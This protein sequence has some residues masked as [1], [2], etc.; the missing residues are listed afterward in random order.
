MNKI[1]IINKIL[2]AEIMISGDWNFV[3]KVYNEKTLSDLHLYHFFQKQH[4]LWMRLP[5]IYPIITFTYRKV[6]FYPIRNSIENPYS[7]TVEP[8]EHI[9]DSSKQK[10]YLC[11]LNFID[12]NGMESHLKL[13]R[14]TENINNTLHVCKVCNESVVDKELNIQCSKCL[15]IYH[16]NCTALKEARGKWKSV[17]WQCS[18]CIA[19]SSTTIE[20]SSSRVKLPSLL[21]RQRKSNVNI[22]DPQIEFLK[23]QV[24]TLKGVIV[25][26]N[27]EIRKLKQSNELKAKRIN[28][29]ESQIRNV[30]TKSASEV[31]DSDS[32]TSDLKINLLEQKLANAMKQMN[33]MNVKLAELDQRMTTRIYHCTDCNFETLQD[34]NLRKHM[35]ESH[36]KFPS[37]NRISTSSCNNCR[38]ESQTHDPLND[39]N[40]ET[41]ELDSFPCDACKYFAFS[42]NDLDRHQNVMH[43]KNLKCRKCSTEFQ[44]LNRL[45]LHLKEDHRPSRI[46]HR[47]KL[48]HRESNPILPDRHL[49]QP[50]PNKKTTTQISLAEESP[51]CESSSEGTRQNCTKCK[52]SFTHED[53]YQHRRISRHSLGGRRLMLP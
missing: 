27:D 37:D 52:K 25:Q 36:L 33:S 2:L 38:L 5:I 23:S 10:W 1:K 35:Q 16:K 31:A 29:L 46:F 28:Q 9:R 34:I 17:N 14:Y 20:T 40:I 6:K 51:L 30:C 44:S 8:E 4:K 49:S 32:S 11:D 7:K 15:H 13:H 26:N 47:Q 3:T 43:G 53:E 45:K 22:D 21:G 50:Q 12:E 19:S 18:L 42:L 24:D 41:S 48:N 39:H